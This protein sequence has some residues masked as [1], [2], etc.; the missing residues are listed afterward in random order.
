MHLPNII[1]RLGLYTRML[2]VIQQGERASATGAKYENILANMQTD[3]QQQILSK[4][5]TD[6]DLKIE[7]KLITIY[8]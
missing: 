7:Y 4:Y 6:C 3:L 2:K 8:C 1:P 5:W